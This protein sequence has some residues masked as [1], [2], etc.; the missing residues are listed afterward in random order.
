MDLEFTSAEI[1]QDNDRQK[2]E[3]VARLTGPVWNWYSWEFEEET[4]EKWIQFKK[5]DVR[6]VFCIN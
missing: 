4:F 3:L 2:L 6:K 1:F 5:K